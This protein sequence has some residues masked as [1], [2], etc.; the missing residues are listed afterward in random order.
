MP[1]AACDL[2]GEDWRLRINVVMLSTCKEEC[3]SGTVGPVDGALV[4]LNERMPELVA[5]DYAPGDFFGRVTLLTNWLWMDE[6]FDTRLDGLLG[7]VLMT[8]RHIGRVPVRLIVNRITPKLR[9][10]ADQWDFGL[11]LKPEFKGGGGNGR[12]LNRN[13]ICHMAEWFDTEYALTFQDHAFPLRPG[14]EEFLGSWDYV[15]APWPLDCDDW[16]TRILLPHRGHVGNGA[17]TL[18]SRNLCERTAYYYNRH[19]RW[20]P[21]CYLFNDDYF[22]GKTLPSWERNYLKEVRIPPP[23]TAVR[24]AL[25]NNRKLQDSYGQLP[26]GFHGPDAFG[27]LRGR[28][29]VAV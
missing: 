22:I 13:T 28:G 23:E 2:A 25:E 14:L 9:K 26:F 12:D 8:W 5:A 4:W 19:F 3:G 6:R 11:I 10:M 29:L 21:H 24:F 18:R 15:G 1:F 16:I 27:Y 17:F 20:F 7:S